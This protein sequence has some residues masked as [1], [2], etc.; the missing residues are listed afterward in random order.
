MELRLLTKVTESDTPFDGSAVLHL[1]RGKKKYYKE[2]EIL[3]FYCPY[4]GEWL[5]VPRVIEVERK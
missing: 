4:H 2:E 3:Q 1:P 5:D